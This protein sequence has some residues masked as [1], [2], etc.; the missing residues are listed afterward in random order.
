MGNNA[1]LLAGINGAG[2]DGT[3]LAWFAQS[4]SPAPTDSTTALTSVSANYKNAG[5]ITENGLTIK[6]AESTKKIKAYGSPAAQRTIVTDQ[7]YS[8]S[9]EMLETNPVSQAVFHRLS[10]SSI[11]PTVGTGAFSLTSGTYSPIRYAGVFDIIDGTN[12]IRAYCPAIEV[13]GRHDVKVGNG[14]EISWGVDMTAYP[15]SSGV[16]IQW[17]FLVSALG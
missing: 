3:G 9:L 16:A 14:N 2:A 6:F 4:G 7:E 15:N 17:Y 13:T 5:L 10:L 11:S 1:N 8:F 12:H